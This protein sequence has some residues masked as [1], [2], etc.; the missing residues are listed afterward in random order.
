MYYNTEEIKRWILSFGRHAVVLEPE[1]LRRE[2]RE[3]L[4][5]MSA[6]YG[7]GRVAEDALS[8]KPLGR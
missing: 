3:E 8:E 5:A 2:I 4:G 6:A 7:D 1:E